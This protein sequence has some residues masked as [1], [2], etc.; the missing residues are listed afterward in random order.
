M[1]KKGLIFFTF[2]IFLITKINIQAS[3]S[4]TESLQILKNALLTIPDTAKRFHDFLF[5]QIKNF[6]NINSP[7]AMLSSYKVYQQLHYFGCL[8]TV[9]SD[10][11]TKLKNIL[12]KDTQWEKQ[13]LSTIQNIKTAVDMTQKA[14]PPSIPFL[15]TVVQVS[16]GIQSILENFAKGN[17][18]GIMGCPYSQECKIIISDL[19]TQ[20]ATIESSLKAQLT[21]IIQSKTGGTK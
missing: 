14:L 2:L 4:E 1:G 15:Q 3:Q 12:Y 11:A 8:N 17:K 5:S 16:S 9:E 21:K 19:Q 10:P 20:F 13:S 7:A 18:W 6:P